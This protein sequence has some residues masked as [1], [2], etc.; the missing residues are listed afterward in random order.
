MKVIKEIKMLNSISRF[1]WISTG[2]L[3]F[4]RILKE[5]SGLE[6]MP[7]ESIAL[8]LNQGVLIIDWN[9]FKVEPGGCML[10][11]MTS[12]GLVPTGH[13]W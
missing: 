11:K 2:L 5:I 8:I 6:Q 1:G 9:P 12:C 4:A 3:L 7:M 10:L 13:N